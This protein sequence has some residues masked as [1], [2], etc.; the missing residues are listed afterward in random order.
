[1]Q[2]CVGR[3]GEFM[4]WFIVLAFALVFP[5]RDVAAQGVSASLLSD[6]H[7]LTAGTPPPGPRP[8][9]TRDDAVKDTFNVGLGFTLGGFRSSS[10]NS[11]VGGLKSSVTYYFREHLAV[12]ATITSTFDLQ[13]SND[14]DAKYVFYGGG[15]KVRWG[16]RKLRPFVHALLGGV[17]LFPQTA[18]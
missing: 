7:V 10:F 1:M 3:W 4:K 15:L 18:Y 12:E 16:R 17:H 13:S 6:A 5:L 2:Q 11:L 14:S 8:Q 9:T